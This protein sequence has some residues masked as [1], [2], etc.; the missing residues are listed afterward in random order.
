M[1]IFDTSTLILLVKIDLLRKVLERFTG[2]IT[3]S[4]QKEATYK[5]SLDARIIIQYITEKRLLVN[6]DPPSSQVKKILKD[7]SL[8]KGEATA[9]LLAKEKKGILA[10]DDRVA[11]KICKVFNVPFVT[12]IHLLIEM[13]KKGKINKEISLAKLKLLKEYGRYST[14]IMKDAIERIGGE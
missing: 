9:L 6:P 12:A 13:K 3:E 1:L 14:D 7:F 11:I 5:N 4:V 8:G 10:T 2:I